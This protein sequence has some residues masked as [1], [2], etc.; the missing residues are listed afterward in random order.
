M[1]TALFLLSLLA[2]GAQAKQYTCVSTAFRQNSGLEHKANA[3][4]VFDVK[5]DESGVVSLQGFL[6][7]VL[8]SDAEEELVYNYYS[9]FALETVANN[10]AYVPRVYTD[11][12]QFVDVDEKMSNGWDGGGMNGN[13]VIEKVVLDGAKTAKAHYIFQSGDHMGGTID[14]DCSS[15]Y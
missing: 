14:F 4:F 1:K 13:L 6:G 10:V 15:K 3:R 12:L 8:V 9:V 11:H 2:L 5:K 7:H